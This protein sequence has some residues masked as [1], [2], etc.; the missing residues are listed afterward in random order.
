[1]ETNGLGI[2]TVMAAPVITFPLAF[3]LTRV[4][5]NGV[6]RLLGR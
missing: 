4:C 6:M 1:M 5:L 2:L 3:L